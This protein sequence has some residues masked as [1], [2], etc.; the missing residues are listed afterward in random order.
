MAEPIEPQQLLDQAWAIAL[1]EEPEADRTGTEFGEVLAGIRGGV[2]EPLTTA[3]YRRAISS[4]YYGL[5]HAITLA[6]ASVLAPTT[7][8]RHELVRLF[9]HRD[10]KAVTGWITGGSYPEGL[11][12]SVALLR[13]DERVRAISTSFQQLSKAREDADY[14]HAASFKQS[15]VY[16]FVRLAQ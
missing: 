3:D 10:L 9:N 14:N 6:A 4:A 12:I 16:E 8:S 5:F 1:I 13:A 15:D 11:G 2:R 7:E